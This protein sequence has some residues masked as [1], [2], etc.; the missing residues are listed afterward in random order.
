ME[1]NL[2]TMLKD[3]CCSR[4]KN[5]FEEKDIT[6]IHSDGVYNVINITCSKCGKDFGTIYLKFT[7]N[8]SENIKD[9]ILKD[10]RD[11][12]PISSDDVIDAHEYIKD[13]EK[14]FEK[15]LNED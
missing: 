11:K 10:T 8:T 14:N 4:C 9:L 3:L 13:I 15:F 12:P 1:K 2:A 7:E 6:F 5:D